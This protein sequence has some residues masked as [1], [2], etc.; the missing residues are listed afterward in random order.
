MVIIVKNKS[1]LNY[2]A[3]VLEDSYILLGFVLFWYISLRDFKILWRIVKN[4]L[5]SQRKRANRNVYV[6]SWLDLL[7]RERH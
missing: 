3:L 2:G 6:G 5:R 4:S 1:Q 7:E